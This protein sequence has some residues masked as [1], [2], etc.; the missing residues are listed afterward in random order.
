MI[1]VA[2]VSTVQDPISGWLDNFNGPVG[3]LIGGGK[4]LLRV[5][6]VDPTASS[7]Y[8][9]VDVAIKA[10]LT[11][12]WKRGLQTYNKREIESIR[13]DFTFEMLSGL[14]KI[15][16]FTCTTALPIRSVGSSSTSWSRW[17]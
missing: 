13:R 9:P 12:A 6:C 4:G 7:D 17:V 2:V 15:P 16:A 3:M 5:V 11:C 10:M 1:C 8:L 14:P